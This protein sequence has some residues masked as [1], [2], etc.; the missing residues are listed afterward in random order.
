MFR[1]ATQENPILK[2]AS[3]DF[4]SGLP[5]SEPPFKIYLYLVSIYFEGSEG[6]R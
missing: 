1:Y 4:T 6:V 3:E 2:C 5:S